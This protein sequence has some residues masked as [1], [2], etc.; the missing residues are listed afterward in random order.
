M[1]TSARRRSPSYILH[2]A[3]LDVY[4]SP[5]SVLCE[6]SWSLARIGQKLDITADTIL[7]ADVTVRMRRDE[8]GDN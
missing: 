5:P 8:N 3:E 6:A 2:V 1:Y 7:A 4:A